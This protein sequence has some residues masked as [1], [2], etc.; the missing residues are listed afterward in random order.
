MGLATTTAQAMY[1]FAPLL[2]SAAIS[3][4]VLRYGLWP[5]MARPVDGG[6]TFRGRRLFGDSKTWRGLTCSLIG[7]TAAV[8]VQKY[9]VGDR[10]AALAVID[11]EQVS[12]LA[13]GLALGGGAVLGELP[14]SFVKR[15]LGISPGTRPGGALGPLFYVLDQVDLLVGTWPLLLFWFRPS[16]SLVVVSIV[17][18][19]AVHQAVSLI[20]YLIGARAG[21]I[22]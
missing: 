17:L 13:L 2:G 3:G 22:P 1:L 20:G 19:F 9:V 7:C 14:N 18:I 8:A 12:V 5:A 10:A 6:L 4:I 15:Q 11:Y 21:V 16:R